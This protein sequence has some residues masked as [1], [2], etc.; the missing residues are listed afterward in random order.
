M[1][2]R[3]GLPIFLLAWSLFLLAFLMRAPDGQFFSGDST[4]KYMQIR[5]LNESG[6]RDVTLPDRSLEL[7]PNG[8]L[9][10]YLE[11]NVHRH[12]GRL[13]AVF[14]V[15]FAYL[16]ALPVALLGLPGLSLWPWLG[17]LASLLLT[18]RLA[19]RW[20]GPDLVLPAVALTA[21]ATPLTFYSLTFWEH[22][23]AVALIL[24]AVERL[25]AAPLARG[26][27]ITA[28]LSLGVA[29]MLRT[30]A[31]VVAALVG[32]GL[33]TT[34][35]GRREVPLFALAVLPGTLG[36]LALNHQ[37]TGTWLPHAT[38]NWRTGLL[39]EASEGLPRA[40]LGRLRH[41][42]VAA[43]R[44]SN[45]ELPALVILGAL[46]WIGRRPHRHESFSRSAE[47]L[48]AGALVLR[49][50][51]VFGFVGDPDPQL[52]VLH[53]GGLLFFAPLLPFVLARWRT[54]VLGPLRGPLL[55]AGA[56]VLAMAVA[57]PNAGGMQYG[58]RY[59]LF[60]CPLLI[61]A[62]LAAVADGPKRNRVWALAAVA[63]ALLIQ[64]RGLE[65]SATRQTN[66]GR[67]AEV[68]RESEAETIVCSE[69][70]IPYETGTLAAERRFLV[71]S[72]MR[73]LPELFPRLEALGERRVLV[74]LQGLGASLALPERVRQSYDIEVTGADLDQAQTEFLDLSYR[75]VSFSRRAETK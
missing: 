50:V 74:L 23:T 28:G 1:A 60:L 2:S 22:T 30:E 69:W 64:A 26:A 41:F 4:L 44:P 75:V 56:F 27:V 61:L 58:H 9:S 29:G 39:I 45:L 18:A 48:I 54:L 36:V 73:L 31:L 51:Y 72:D 43:N 55:L 70:W 3:L 67:L 63:L 33:L 62:G 68:V 20:L 32:A 59:L 16:N 57:A 38:V 8:A 65:I 6:G 12:G 42:L 19:R 10:P 7:A 17:G 15:A 53:S 66:N 71:L 5:A 25:T 21:F 13:F 37:L 24:L 40:I 14:P 34:R 46:L 11:P 52:G 47:F 35:S 49:A